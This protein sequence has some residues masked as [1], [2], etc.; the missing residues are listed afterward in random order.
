MKKIKEALKELNLSDK[1]TEVYLALLISGTQSATK[2]SKKAK[3]NRVTT[4]HLLKSLIE[5]G[6]VS[7]V[8]KSNVK[9]FRAAD[10]KTILR[11]IKEKEEK[12]TEILPD[13]EALKES[14]LEHPQ[15]QIYEGKEGL[16]SIMDDWINTKKEI[17]ALGSEELNN[18]LQFYFPHY[19]KRRVKEKIKIK[20]MFK[21]SKYSQKMKKNDK[22]EFRE[23]K[24]IETKKLTTGVYVYGNKASFL[25]FIK[26]EPL[27]LIIE[28]KSIVETIRT[29]LN[30]LWL[31]AKKN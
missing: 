5:K 21:K 18:I 4:Y 10:P 15:I 16:K 7:Y 26:T 19:L 29:M 8:I 23:T 27:G 31:N 2:V 30:L 25:T 20:I 11:K 6:L 28:D 13:L 22:S 24:F 3:L 12:F 17:I 9:Y 14:L 1:E